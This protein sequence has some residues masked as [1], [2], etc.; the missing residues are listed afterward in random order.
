MKKSL[1]SGRDRLRVAG[2]VSGMLVGILVCL[3]YWRSSPGLLYHGKS[4]KVWAAQLYAPGPERRDEAAAAFKTMGPQAVPELIRMLQAQDSFFRHLAWNLPQALPQRFKL[5]MVRNVR[6]PQAAF[7][8][9]SA[10]HAAGIIGP[11]AKAAIP[12][13][14]RVMYWEAA[15]VTR[16]VVRG[17]RSEV[18]DAEVCWEAAEALVRMGE[19]AMPEMLNALADPDDK[20]RR[21]AAYALIS[22]GPVAGKRAVPALIGRLKD[23]KEPV[24]SASAQALAGIGAPAVPALLHAIEHEKGS[25]RRLAAQVLMGLGASRRLAGPPLLLM[26]QDE[27]PASRRQALETLAGIHAADEAIIRAIVVALQ[28]ADSEV[29]LAAAKALGELSWKAQ[30]AVP[31]LI[32]ALQDPSA[33]LREA[34][35][36]SLGKIGPPAK[37]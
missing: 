9:R 32:Q 10:A 28:D 18:A 1:L 33:A 12:A 20:L 37:P 19:D 13:L 8:R 7:V 4:I 11:D 26:L 3:V 30:P 34:V 29:R 21:V 22:A 27:D 24:R 16:C 2:C 25:V 17:A 23:P 36:C 5:F 14:T 35:A 15:E 6:M 31:A